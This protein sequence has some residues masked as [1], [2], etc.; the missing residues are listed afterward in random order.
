[1]GLFQGVG[2]IK[3]AKCLPMREGGYNGSQWCRHRGAG[4][5]QDT[6]VSIHFGGSRAA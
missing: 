3:D 1:M 4:L 2:A 6:V 5:S